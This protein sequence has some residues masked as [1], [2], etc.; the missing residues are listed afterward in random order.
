MNGSRSR[1]LLIATAA[2]A[3]LLS[4]CAYDSYAVAGYGYAGTAYY[5]GYYGPY[6]DGFW[7]VDGVFNFYDVRDHRYH[8]DDGYHFRHD[9]S[10]GYAGVQ[11]RGFEGRNFARGSVPA[12]RA[13]A[14]GGRGG[15]GRAG[16]GGGP[17]GGGGGGG[18]RRG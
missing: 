10:P 12:P 17:R 7:G 13:Y 9:N 2:T 6:W 8:R 18:G 1:T 16:G 11:H 4:G 5:D 14:G 15:G 3:F